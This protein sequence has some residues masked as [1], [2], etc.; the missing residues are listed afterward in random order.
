[1]SAPASSTS[2]IPSGVKVCMTFPEILMFG[3]FVFGGLVWILVAS[4]RVS[5]AADQGWVMFVSVFCFVITTLLLILY[6][7]G[8]QN[9]SSAWTAV[10]VFYHFIAAVFYLSI[11]VLEASDTRFLLFGIERIHRINIAATVF[12]FLAT[13]LYT[14][15]GIFSILRWKSSS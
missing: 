14:I 2:P 9:S 7:A 15:H 13:L 6:M 10:D 11:A 3:E 5:F 8:V 4:A 1:M 12:A